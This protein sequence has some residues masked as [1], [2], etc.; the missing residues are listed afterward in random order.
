MGLQAG[1][2]GQQ[3]GQQK[4]RPQQA[5]SSS[6]TP[7]HMLVPPPPPQEPGAE[8][9]RL[10]EEFFQGLV[11]EEH[12]HPDDWDPEIHGQIYPGKGSSPQAYFQRMAE[13]VKP[14]GVKKERR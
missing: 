7:V 2:P 5:A 8:P 13:K 9:P 4:G 1:R 11:Q 3:A 6:T 10:V 12:E 14:K